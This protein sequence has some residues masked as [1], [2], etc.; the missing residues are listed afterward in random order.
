[1]TRPAILCAC[2]ALLCTMAIPGTAEPPSSGGLDMRRTPYLV[3]RIPLT[4]SAPGPAA[5]GGS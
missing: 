1:M 4:R 5:G 2:C 3:A